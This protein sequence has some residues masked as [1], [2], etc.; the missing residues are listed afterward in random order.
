MQGLRGFAINNKQM[1]TG[2]SKSRVAVPSLEWKPEARSSASISSTT[3]TGSTIRT[4][5]DAPIWNPFRLDR[6]EAEELLSKAEPGAF[7]FSHDVTSELFLSISMGKY[8][9]HHAILTRDHGYYVGAKR[10]S[11]I[12]AVVDY[13]KAHPLG[14]TFLKEECRSSMP[15]CTSQIQIK[16][17]ADLTISCPPVIQK[18]E[19]YE[20]FE[21]DHTLSF[22]QI[23]CAA[24]SRSQIATQTSNYGS[25]HAQSL[26]KQDGRVL[27]PMQQDHQE[28]PDIIH[29]QADATSKRLLTRSMAIDRQDSSGEIKEASLSP[30]VIPRSSAIK[31]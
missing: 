12:G 18:P 6:T 25:A 10:F 26:K 13:F 5:T 1:G 31:S 23:T 4:L 8:V 20:L 27:V 19:Q 7:I 9:C 17:H 2:C 15:K 24:E 28:R 30:L 22:M 16:Q 29:R 11:T 14:E 21:E 3:N